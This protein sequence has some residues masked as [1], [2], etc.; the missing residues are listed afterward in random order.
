MNIQTHTY[1]QLC[2][3][4]QNQEV[5]TRQADNHAGFYGPNNKSPDSWT[6]GLLLSFA[7]E[8]V[9]FCFQKVRYFFSGSMGFSPPSALQSARYKWNILKRDIKMDCGGNSRTKST[10]II[11]TVLENANHF[12]FQGV[13]IAKLWVFHSLCFISLFS[14]PSANISY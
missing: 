7:S 9:K 1:I 4:R 6:L 12:F 11:T 8:K 3:T 10:D 2:C 5:D 13:D 14:G